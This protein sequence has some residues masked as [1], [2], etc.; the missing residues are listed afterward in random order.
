MIT[1]EIR[2]IKPG[3]PTS[4]CGCT[5]CAAIC[6]KK[7]ITMQADSMGFLYPNVDKALCTNCGLCTSTCAFH[8]NDK[9]SA[10]IEEQG[11]Y[12][13]RLKDENELKK[14]R[15]GGAAWAL[16]TSFLR[17]EGVVYGVVC[18]SVTHVVHKRAVS[19]EECQAMRG[20]KYVQSDMRGV[21]PQVKADLQAGR[22][23]LFTGTACQVAGLLSYLPEKLHERLTTVDIVCHGV[24]SPA[25]WESYVKYV[26]RKY[27]GQ[28]VAADFRDKKY[29][30]HSHNETFRLQDGRELML[31]YFRQLFYAHRILRPSCSVCPFTKFQRVSDITVSDFWG[32]EKH[33]S[34][35]N[36]DRGVSLMLVNTEKGELL[37][38][39]TDLSFIAS[40]REEC[41]QPQ[42]Q[43]PAAI[44]WPRY[45]RARQAFEKGGM[46][47]LLQAEA[48]IGWPLLRQRIIW[49]IKSL[50]GK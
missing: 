1:P 36:D 12:G 20:S 8:A 14:S 44:D 23:V 30:W 13:C 2:H 37:R 6:P 19:I 28:V 49:K 21:F 29:G 17:Q 25:V 10:S 34:E 35:W 4:C 39:D 15:S 45:K 5:A 16:I 9:T 18:E 24:P 27:A 31:A 11:V 46:E 38:K 22:R 42:L 3:S 7:A 48:M 32:W 41:L 26:E 40:N 47:G 33:H 43:A 50:I